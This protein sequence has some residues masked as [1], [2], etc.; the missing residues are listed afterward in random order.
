[1]HCCLMFV[2]QIFAGKIFLVVVLDRFFSHF[3][4]K[5][6]VAGPV[7]QLVVVC[8][9]DCMGICLGGLSIGGL[10]RLIEVVV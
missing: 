9:N 6:V 5:K 2:S 8:S 7:R 10:G 1:M 4:D 3:G